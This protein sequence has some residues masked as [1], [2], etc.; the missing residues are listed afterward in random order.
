MD[1]VCVVKKR[2]NLMG[3]VKESWARVTEIVHELCV[4]FWRLCYVESSLLRVIRGRFN[5]E[6]NIFYFAVILG[7][8][9]TLGKADTLH[10]RFKVILQVFEPPVIL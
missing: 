1:F 3:R 4:C 10:A 5:D 2:E 7:G 8:C 9:T 6:V